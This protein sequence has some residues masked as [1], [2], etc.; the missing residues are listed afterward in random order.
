MAKDRILATKLGVA[1]IEAIIAGKTAIMIGETA[2]NIAEVPLAISVQ[3]TKQVN[4]QLLTAQNSIL[5]IAEL[6]K[7]HKL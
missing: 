7:I 3:H 4:T 5:D 6:A 1:A 2:G